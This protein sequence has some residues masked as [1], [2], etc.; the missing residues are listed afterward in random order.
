MKTKRVRVERG[1]PKLSLVALIDVVLFLL[2]YFIIATE[3][4]PDESQLSAALKTDARGGAAGQLTP[5]VLTVSRGPTYQI[6]DR[7]I[8]SR[9]ALAEVA[10]RLSKEAG[11]VVRVADDADAGGV[12]EAIQVFHEAG[13]TRIS[14]APARR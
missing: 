9:E 8:G 14:Y 11:I 3:L 13:F 1:M 2:L 4:T 12:A 5:Q 7:V 10:R 6:G